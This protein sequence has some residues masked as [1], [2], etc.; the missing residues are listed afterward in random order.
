MATSYPTI[1]GDD[2]RQYFELSEGSSNKFWEIWTDGSRVFTRYGRIGSK[3]QTTVKVVSSPAEA[4]DLHDKLVREKTGKGYAERSEPAA[5]A[6]VVDAPTPRKKAPPRTKALPPAAAGWPAR[7]RAFIANKE[8]DRHSYRFTP[9]SYLRLPLEFD[10]PEKLHDEALRN[11]SQLQ[12]QGD[13]YPKHP[14]FRALAVYAITND[15]EGEIHAEANPSDVE[16]FFLV[17]TSKEACPVLLWTH[18]TRFPN[19]E[20][21]SDTLDAFLASLTA[22]PKKA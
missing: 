18:D 16:E 6:V 17:D 22:R 12:D 7:Y 9:H 19:L 21:V 11:F 14:Q 5:P 8:Y 1:G 2:V 13:W 4:Q 10:E 20:K 15:E 3:G